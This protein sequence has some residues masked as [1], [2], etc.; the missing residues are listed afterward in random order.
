MTIEQL[1]KRWHVLPNNVQGAAWLIV[2]GLMFTLM[3]VGIRAAGQRLPSVEIVFLRTAFQLVFI[4]PMI[5]QVGISGLRTDR[6]RLHAFRALL[7]AMTVQCTFYAFTKLPLTD[8][9]A[10]SF[11]RSLFLTVLAVV[12]LKEMVGVHRW[13]ATF[14]GFIGVII[15]VTPGSGTMQ[16]A[17]LVALAGALL[18]AAMSVTVRMLSSTET[19]VQIMLFPTLINLAISIPLAAAFWVTPYWSE[20]AI[21]AAAAAAGFVGQWCM[22]EAFRVGE[23]SALA[24]MNYLRL[25]FATLFGYLFFHELPGSNT[26]FGAMLIVAA[27]L[28]TVHRE[29]VAHRQQKSLN[30]S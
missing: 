4:M 8:V 5:W 11:S 24:P 12:V 28:Y 16:F 9:T 2:S 23:A 21:I 20:V 18:S 29:S 3:S 30:K 13:S 25:L 6:V 27:T 26:I 22:I 17:A 7:A 14:L 1:R 15:I 19:N 10:I